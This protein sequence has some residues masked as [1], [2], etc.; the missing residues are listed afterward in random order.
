MHF[1][2]EQQA[3]FEAGIAEVRNA[4]AEVKETAAKQ[5]ESIVGLLQVSRMLVDSQIAAEGRMAK[6][7]ERM[8][9]LAA[10]EKRTDERLD[11]F[12][13]FFERHVNRSPG[14]EQAK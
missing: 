9:D 3:K 4:I 8:A 11:S 5:N 10:A 12:I 2:L 6:I 1:I 7:Q 13:D 14:G